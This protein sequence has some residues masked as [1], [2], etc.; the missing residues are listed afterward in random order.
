LL[1]PGQAGEACEPSKSN[2]FF[3]NR[4]TLEIKLLSLLQSS[5]GEGIIFFMFVPQTR[6]TFPTIL[7]E[8]PALLRSWDVNKLRWR[9]HL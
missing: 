6:A 5:R 7:A 2:G 8:Q 3:G 4:N 1:L 9:S